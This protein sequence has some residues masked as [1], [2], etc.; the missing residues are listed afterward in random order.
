MSPKLFNLLLL[1]LSGVLYYMVIA[2]LYTGED[3]GLWAPSQGI[4]SLLKVRSQYEETGRGIKG[5]VDKANK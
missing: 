3:S 5:I 1:I 4:T 2:P